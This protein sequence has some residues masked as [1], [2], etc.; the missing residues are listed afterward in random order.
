[1]SP[2]RSGP[3]PYVFIVG[4][5]RSGTTLLRRVVNAHSWI[6]V[7][8]ETHWVPEF[9]KRRTGLTPEG[10]VTEELV[11]ALIGHPKFVNL[12]MTPG[13]LRGL[14]GPG[15]PP[16][17]ASFVSRIYGRCAA[18]HGKP[19][20]GDKTPN[21][22]RQIF[23]LHDLW[24]RARF[25]HLIRD[26]REVGL[27]LLDWKRKNTRM[28]ELFPTWA[29]DPV[30]TAALCW[31]RDVRRGRDRGR[32]LGPALYREI[33]YE[34][35]V[36]H[37]ADEARD[38]CSF[39]E[40]PYEAGMLEFHQ[41]RTRPGPGRSAKEAW[42]PITRGLRDWRTQMAPEDVERFEAAAGDLLDELGY[43]RACPSPPPAARERAA[44]L[45]ERFARGL[46]AGR[47]VSG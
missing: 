41:G 2:E 4:S 22:V 43:S 6:A 30:T 5:P 42:L 8:P 16:D 18:A 25:I 15:E 10:L 19:L 28:A 29:E 39:L 37:P 23:V 3:N 13:E 26:G 7:P 46:A 21:Y 17:Y 44:R 38:L 47:E 24:P 32:P 9:Y 11:R 34:D 12:G 31:A 33:R 36:H 27:S 40:I 45:R 35:L 20:A 1:M 14:L